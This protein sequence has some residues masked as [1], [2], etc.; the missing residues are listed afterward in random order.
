MNHFFPFLPERLG[1]VS[2]SRVQES[3]WFSAL[4][5]AVEGL[6]IFLGLSGSRRQFGADIRDGDEVRANLERLL[7]QPVER[8]ATPDAVNYF[9]AGLPD[10]ELADI[11]V[12]MTAHL[13]RQRSLEDFRFLDRYW[14]MAMDGT[15]MFSFH[16]EHCPRCLVRRHRDGTV[17]Y[18]HSVLEAKLVTDT[19][20]AFTMGCEFIEN[21][22]RRYRKQ[23]CERNHFPA[24]AKKI[25][26]RFPRLPLCVLL[27]SLYACKPV[28]DILLRYGWA[29]F[30]AFKRGSIPTLYEEAM[31]RIERPDA[32]VV[33]E[34]DEDGRVYTFRW[35]CNLTYR[36]HTLHAIVCDV[37]QPDT[38]KTNRFMYLTD[39]R[40]DASIV[41]KL[42]NLGGRQRFKIENVGFNVQKNCGYGLEHCYG[43]KDYAWK[44]YYH[45][46]QMAHTLHQVMQHT[47]L[48]ARLLREAGHEV[49]VCTSGL[50]VFTSLRNLG[51]MLI[52]SFAHRAL[53]TFALDAAFAA[54]IRPR[55]VFDSS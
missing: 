41:K 30:I 43:G 8:I 4:Q 32:E 38:G 50:D 7:E 15:E 19:G 47:D 55:W 21:S 45:L 11:A 31:R 26:K 46:I 35:A 29:F 51:R 25:R 1:T 48:Q 17:D 12:E 5:L 42:I 10:R 53:S 22:A 9:L 24:L 40:P 3:C 49:P 14:L 27:D 16:H 20:L 33:R 37:Y 2:D 54:F 39:I 28:L 34:I 52:H 18:F 23:T 36:T 44:N 6:L 13:L